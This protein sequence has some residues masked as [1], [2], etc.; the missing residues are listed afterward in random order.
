MKLFEVSAL[1]DHNLQDSLKELS[2]QAI[3]RNGMY[4]IERSVPTLQD[5]CYR[6]IAQKVN[7]REEI[8]NLPLPSMVKSYLSSFS[9]VSESNQTFEKQIKELKKNKRHFLLRKISNLFKFRDK[10]GSN[11]SFSRIFSF[12]L[13]Q[14]NN[15][16]R[17][18]IFT[19]S[20]I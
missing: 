1:C 6:C 15:L 2:R 14:K 9:S 19:K 11:Q 16:R 18:T 17:R 5:L 8:D 12:N 4:D 13:T 10:V 3:A 20:Q 7:R